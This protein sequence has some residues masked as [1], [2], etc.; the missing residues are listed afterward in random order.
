MTEQNNYLGTDDAQGISHEDE[1]T[2]EA[3]S[4][5]GSLFWLFA[6]F[7]LVILPFAVVPGKRPLGWI[8]EPWSWPATVLVIALVGGGGIVLDY[9]RLRRRPDF[10]MKARHAFDGT[11]RS[12]AYAAAFLAYI[13]G[14][15]LIGF[16]LASVIFMQAVYY[17]SGLRGAKWSV[18]GFAVTVAIVLAFRVGL[19]IWFPLPPLMNLF[20]NW[21]SNAVGDYL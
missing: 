13:G 1:V 4:L 9:L 21:V 20:P 5:S 16:T 8:Q 10:S 14:V 3:G 17:M 18:V 2:P 6:V 19:G 12:L 11:A 7:A 15:G